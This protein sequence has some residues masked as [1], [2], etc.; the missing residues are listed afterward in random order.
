MTLSARPH[1][2]PLPSLSLSFLPLCFS[3]LTT[4]LPLTLKFWRTTRFILIFSLE[5]VSSENTI[6]TWGERERERGRERERKTGEREKDR[7]EGGRQEK[8]TQRK[9]GRKRKEE[10]KVCECIRCAHHKTYQ[11]VCPQQ[12]TVSF[13]LFPFNKTVSPLNNCNSSIFSYNINNFSNNVILIKEQ[14]TWERATT[15]LSSFTAS[16]TIKRLGLDFWLR[17]AVASLP[18]GEGRGIKLRNIKENYHLLYL[19]GHLENVYL[20]ELSQLN[21]PRATWPSEA[22]Q[23]LLEFSR[24][25]MMVPHRDLV[26]R[27]W[28]WMTVSSS[29]VVS[30]R[31]GRE[32]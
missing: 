1:F 10:G 15:E 13:L 18:L 3:Y 20:S 28:I 8:G 24:L 25:Y 29:L 16:S 5:I 26:M 4:S 2:F 30:K 17:M 27:S 21:I 14:V 6:Q 9:R 11:W 19:L 12:P 31:T 7:R 23:K 22:S 32:S